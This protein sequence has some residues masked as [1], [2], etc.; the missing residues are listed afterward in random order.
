MNPDYIF[1][2]ADVL[3]NGEMKGENLKDIDFKTIGSNVHS[4]RYLIE[5]FEKINKEIL[6]SR[7]KNAIKVKI[8]L[9]STNLDTPINENLEKKYRGAKHCSNGMLGVRPFGHLLY[10]SGFAMKGKTVVVVSDDP[11]LKEAHYNLMSLNK[12]I[13]NT[14]LEKLNNQ[15]FAFR[16]SNSLE[17]TLTCNANIEDEAPNKSMKD[18]LSSEDKKVADMWQNNYNDLSKMVSDTVVKKNGKFRKD[19]KL[20]KGGMIP[21]WENSDEVE[22]ATNRN[23]YVNQMKVL[24][25]K[26]KEK[27]GKDWFFD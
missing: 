1:P 11:L 24:E 14:T 7:N 21:S 23:N 10:A 25:Y 4:S 19:G 9:D 26:A 2:A 12:V 15:N 27:F 16:S 5:D 18:C 3:Y 8:M 6:N 13:G 17:N 22:F 20:R